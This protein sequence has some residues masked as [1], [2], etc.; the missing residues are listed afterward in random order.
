MIFSDGVSFVLMA[1][2]MAWFTRPR[3]TG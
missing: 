3:P 1:M 2:V